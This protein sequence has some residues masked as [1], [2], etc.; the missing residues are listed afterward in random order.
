MEAGANGDGVGGRSDDEGAVAVGRWRRPV[1]D[2]GRRDRAQVPW[3]RPVFFADDANGGAGSAGEGG[4][5][6]RADFTDVGGAVNVGVGI[7]SVGGAEESSEVGLV[8]LQ[9]EGPAGDGQGQRTEREGGQRA[10]GEEGESGHEVHGVPGSFVGREREGDEDEQRVEGGPAEE[11]LARSE[12]DDKAG[13]GEEG[14]GELLPQKSSFAVPAEEAEIIPPRLFMSAGA[15][16]RATTGVGVGDDGVV[17]AGEVSTE[18]RLEECGDDE[19]GRQRE[20]EVA[21]EAG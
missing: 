4:L 16:G 9:E 2:G 1:T 15:S 18:G 17:K 14:E 12:G 7:A 20:D 11:F 13:A 3:E 5:D 10:G 6:E 21:R 19:R 8:D